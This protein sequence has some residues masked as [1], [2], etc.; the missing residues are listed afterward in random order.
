[1][2][3]VFAILIAATSS[4]SS[5]TSSTSAGR[6]VSKARDDVVRLH[7]KVIE[8]RDRLLLAVEGDGT[9]EETNL[10]YEAAYKSRKEELERLQVSLRKALKDSKRIN[11]VAKDLQD[12]EDKRSG[13]FSARTKYLES[14][15][16]DSIDEQE[17]K[18]A[19]YIAAKRDYNLM[20]GLGAVSIFSWRNF[21]VILGLVL[22][23]LA[24]RYYLL[25]ALTWRV[26]VLGILCATCFS[27]VLGIFT[28]RPADWFNPEKM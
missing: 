26:Y 1:M 19:A 3:K 23:I 6:L 15:K 13:F 27:I 8:G 22:G 24:V 14:M 16:S 9:N 28:F 5:A 11:A 12:L 10:K 4:A 18:R 7:G 17:M 20:L 25:E 21:L 2:M